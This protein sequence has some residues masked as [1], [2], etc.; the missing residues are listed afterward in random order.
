MRSKPFLIAAAAAGLTAAT[1][2]A[3]ADRGSVG[4]GVVIGGT[5]GALL[6][7]PPGWVAGMA[8]GAAVGESES[9][10]QAR[11][12][13]GGPVYAERPPVHYVPPDYAPARVVYH[14]PAPRVVYYEPAPRVVYVARPYR[15]YYGPR[16]GYYYY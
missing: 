10:R 3:L 8:L 14:A 12:N 16:R 11:H 5:V 7:G 13:Q 4:A 2:P 6:G 15:P 1:F 9:D